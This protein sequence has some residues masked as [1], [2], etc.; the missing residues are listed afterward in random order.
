MAVRPTSDRP[1]RDAIAIGAPMLLLLA[2]IALRFA[3]PLQDGDVFWHMAYARQMLARGTLRLDHAAFSWTPA[4][5]D[6][7]YCAWI[8]ELALDALWEH[9]GRWSVFA[10]RYVVVL[11]VAALAYEQARRLRLLRSLAAHLVVLVL[12]IGSY[13]GTLL[14]PELFSLLL[15]NAT[16]FVVFQA[17]Q[18]ARAP[19]ADPR[20]ALRMLWSL[21]P[22][23]LLW[24]NCHGAF[25]LA[26]PF[27][28]ATVIGETLNR[29]WSPGLALPPRALRHLLASVAV[30]G[31]ATAVNP[32]G[33]A[34]PRQLVRDVMLGGRPRPDVVWNTAHRSLFATLGAPPHLE[35]I[36][37]VMT[38]VLGILLVA[39]ARHGPRGARVDWTIVLANLAYVPLFLG[40]A[41]TTYLWPAVF[42]PSA[43]LLL[44]DSFDHGGPPVLHA[45]ARRAALREIV[46]ALMLYLALVT[47]WDAWARPFT[48]SW[49]GFGIG[50]V[51]PVVEAELLARHPLGRRLYNVHDS[52]GYLLWRLHPAY[53]VM[54]DSRSFPYLSWFDEQY[55]FVGGHD[56]EAFTTRHPADVGVI[57]LDKTALVDRFLA[58]PR[59]RLVFYGPT[60]A[61]FL[62]AGRSP[63]AIDPDLATRLDDLRNG[64]TALRVLDFAARVG[65]GAAVRTIA[66][67]V[68]TRLRWQLSA[69]DVEHAHTVAGRFAAR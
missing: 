59:W 69:D 43:L 66:R 24:A 3:E 56:F 21:P 1:L 16:V 48:N 34:Y 5:T 9:V 46:G 20:R 13:A 6:V 38:A 22:L 58:S 23:V 47:C 40:W 26:A 42:A 63:P 4:R 29:R 27:L 30:A 33:L 53:A 67:Q 54:T 37:V 41:R 39:R 57:D 35:E 60:S 14:K 7:I 52:G 18:A 19:G 11:A 62:P 15:M 28:V 68:E 10:L 65:D 49:L 61:V 32:Y 31:A 12:V 25:V 50:Y 44:R 36:L 45:P 17:K 64:A 55:R 2:V 51:N 8:S